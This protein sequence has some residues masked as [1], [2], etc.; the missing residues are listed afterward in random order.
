RAETLVQELARHP[1]D[2]MPR[3]RELQ[4][5]WQQ[6][7]RS[8]PLER[9]VENVLWSRFKAA[10]DAV[11]AQREAAFNAHDAEL[12]ANLAE[13]EALIA[14]LTSIDLDTTP[15]AEMQRALGDADRAWR[16]PVE[17][18]RAAVKSL[19]TR[20]TAARAALAQAVAESAQKRWFAQCDHLVAKI[21]LC[22][23]RE[24]SPEEAHLS[25]RWAAL[26]ALPV[27]WEKPLAQRWSQAPTAGP[28]SATACEDL[29]LQLEAALDLPA[30]AESLAAR[31]DLKLRALKDALEGRAAQTQDPLAQRAQWFASALR[32]SGMSPAQR[33]RLRALIAALRHAAPGSLGGSA[34]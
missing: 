27:A 33:E 22:E 15:V 32:Q 23:A 20:F 30:S 4:A 11:F 6:H 17:V 7:A 13:R 21:A 29:L 12:A 18:P 28:L 25:E 3:V 5:E 26:A 24:A 9:K 10:T 8:L 2:A 16:Q 19:D 1:R 34:R 14:R 31:R